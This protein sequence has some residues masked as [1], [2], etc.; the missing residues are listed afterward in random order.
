MLRISSCLLLV[1]LLVLAVIRISEALN[2]W[3]YRYVKSVV[4]SGTRKIA[5]IAPMIIST[6]NPFRMP[7][8]KRIDPPPVVVERRE[9]KLED[10]QSRRQH[11]FQFVRAAV[12]SVGPS[13]VRIDCE[14]EVSSL[15]SLFSD[16]KEGEVIRVAGTGI[17]ASSDGYVLTN[18]HVIDSAKK[19][20]ITLSS[21]RSFKAKVVALDEFTD[22][23]V[24]KIDFNGESNLVLKEAPI[25]DSSVLHAGDWVIAVGCP[26]GLDFTVTLGVVSSP[27]RSAVE[28][29]APHLK[30]NYIQ[31]DA[32]LN[33]GNS[34]GPLVND[35]GEVVGINTMVRT[36]TEAIGFAIP[37][38]RAKQV[39]EVLKKGRKPSHAYF[40][41]EVVSLTPDYARIFN[42]DPNVQRLPEVHGALVT[43]VVLG[44]PA[45]KC[46]LRRND[47]IVSVNG[48]NI[49][50]S[51]DADTN[52]DVCIPGRT[53]IVQVARGDNGA[54]HDL[55]VVPQDLHALLEE[56]K[57][58]QSNIV[59]IKPHA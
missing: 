8:P 50:S 46:G 45:D 2:Q 3:S 35:V 19:L 54:R 7:L 14:R 15:M 41:M 20:T 9:R 39:Y 4:L 52:L 12:Q 53:S 16:T 25:G 29:G 10:K 22:L 37:I 33:S 6:V 31:T 27:K 43:R 17:I 49:L 58:Q 26:V 32:A 38:N 5:T 24:V 42:E 56:R 28:V 13:V 48:A 57:R 23:G 44:S 55:Q 18:A 30:G 1:I 40:G 34:G 59:I 36:N 47:I 11:S 51:D 21:G